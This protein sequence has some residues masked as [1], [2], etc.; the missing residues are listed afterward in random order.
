MSRSFPVTHRKA[1]T[2]LLSQLGQ[3]GNLGDDL[4]GCGGDV[5]HGERSVDRCTS[6]VENTNAPPGL[7]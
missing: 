7:W 2:V 5:F 3:R 6:A 1:V 4:V